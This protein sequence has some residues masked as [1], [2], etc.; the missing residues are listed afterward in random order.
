VVREFNDAEL[1]ALRSERKPLP[2]RWHSIRTK[3]ARPG[4][5]SSGG[6]IVFAVRETGHQFRLYARQNINEH[7]DFS[8]GLAFID[9]DG[10]EYMLARY[11][12]NSHDH[13]NVLE[14]EE[15]EGV[16]HIHRATERYLKAFGPDGI[17]RYAVPTTA[18]FDLNSAIAFA[19][20][21]LGCDTSLEDSQQS[22]LFSGGN[23][24]E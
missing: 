3:P 11:N 13:T 18:Y 8:F 24:A 14:G 7:F 4:N 23:D 12:G 22:N 21:E 16:Y 15:L 2:P 1:D 9:A 10:S 5:S 20:P 6:S 17:E 19:L